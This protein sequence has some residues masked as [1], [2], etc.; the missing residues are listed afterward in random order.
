MTKGSAHSPEEER[1]RNEL[2][3]ALQALLPMTL[4]MTQQL[5]GGNDAITRFAGLERESGEPTE[6][7]YRKR[8][9]EE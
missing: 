1:K 4:G 8:P 6:N 2:F 5:E 9:T 3:L 7:I